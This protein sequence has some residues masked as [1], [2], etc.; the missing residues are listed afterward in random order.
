MNDT[1]AARSEK[2]LFFDCETFTRDFSMFILENTTK[3]VLD[4]GR[5]MMIK[6]Y[7]E[8]QAHNKTVLLD[9]TRND[10]FCP[11]VFDG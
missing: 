3:I 11:V 2:L 1:G 5:R 4:E 8:C 10:T 6:L 7:R 9:E